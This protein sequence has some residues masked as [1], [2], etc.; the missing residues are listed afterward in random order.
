MRGWL[1]AVMT[2]RKRSIIWSYFT[3]V[4][5]DEASCDICQKTIR[6]CGNTTN[7]I[8]HLK[9]KHPKEHDEVQLRRA[10]E[11]TET[12]PPSSGLRQSYLAESFQRGGH[13]PGTNQVQ[14]V[15]RLFK[16]KTSCHIYLY[17]LYNTDYFRYEDI[18]VA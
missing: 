9:V 15:I 17:T 13:Y 3:P 8:K 11:V 18:A 2:E 5:N 14:V 16:Y 10:E 12:R 7:M 4:N 6:H 1:A